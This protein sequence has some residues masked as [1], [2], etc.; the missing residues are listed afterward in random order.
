MQ[1]D[2]QQVQDNQKSQQVSAV[3]MALP[4]DFGAVT[5]FSQPS[6]CTDVILSVFLY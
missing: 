4:H 2:C 5:I 3:L 1:E 6:R